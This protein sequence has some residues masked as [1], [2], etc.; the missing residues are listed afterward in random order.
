MPISTDELG[1][2]A[3]VLNE[4]IE[5]VNN[6]VIHLDGKDYTRYDPKEVAR[7]KMDR[8]MYENL[9][10]IGRVV[11]KGF[12]KI[13]KELMITSDKYKLSEI[14]GEL[15]AKVLTAF[16][17]PPDQDGMTPRTAVAFGNHIIWEAKWWPPGDYVKQLVEKRNFMTLPEF[18]V[19]AHIIDDKFHEVGGGNNVPNY[20]T[21][22]PFSQVPKG[23]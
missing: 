3:Y 12:G 11:F 8:F 23:D 7:M 16:F 14:P 21:H 18:Q 1:Y 17:S 22:K 10:A 13:Y 6:W 15:I 2:K 20:I 4:W 5:D 9:V 19:W